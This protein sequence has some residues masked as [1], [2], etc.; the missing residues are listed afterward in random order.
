MFN[1]DL[2]D[3]ALTKEIKAF[4]DP[5]LHFLLMF[6]ENVLEAKLDD[7]YMFISD[8]IDEPIEINDYKLFMIVCCIS[9]DPDTIISV[10]DNLNLD[11]NS[12]YLNNFDL[13][14]ITL[15]ALQCVIERGRDV[16]SSRECKNIEG[17]VTS[18]TDILYQDFGDVGVLFNPSEIG[19]GIFEP[20]SII[21]TPMM[22]YVLN[23]Y[24]NYPFLKLYLDS[25]AYPLENFEYGQS[26]FMICIN[27]YMNVEFQN[28]NTGNPY[29]L[30]FI[31]DMIDTIGP[32]DID[33]V[34]RYLTDR[35]SSFIESLRESVFYLLTKRR[36]IHR[37]NRSRT[38]Y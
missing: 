3:P 18:L 24:F 35:E 27:E 34:F 21:A 28:V 36:K 29:M 13:Y 9:T 32:E 11:V 25:G 30:V 14:P 38:N 20:Q 23:H 4:I 33:M 7:V 17:Q 37:K 2:Y 31:S 12:P 22:L 26:V 16:V 1:P 15:E 5:R 6:R 19:Y 10:I 8:I